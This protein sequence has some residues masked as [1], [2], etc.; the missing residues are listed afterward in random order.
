MTDIIDRIRKVAPSEIDKFHADIERR[1]I[2]D[3]FEVDKILKDV[4]TKI[5]V[6]SLAPELS[7]R[8]NQIKNRIS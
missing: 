6:D 4:F 5:D 3:D 7:W 1:K 8:Y 2:L